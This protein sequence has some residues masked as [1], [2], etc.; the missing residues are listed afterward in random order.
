MFLVRRVFKVK[1]GTGRKAAE[2]ITQI[3]QMYDGAG[4]RTPSRV[5]LSGSTVPGP[6]D[7]VYMDW[8]AET[9][10]SAYRPDNVA[11]KPTGEDDL[12]AKLREYQE[13][14]YIEFY[15]MYSGA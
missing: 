10:E 14:T 3:G 6:A 9:L 2:V 1:K 4:Q 12:F 5:Y 11:A 7:T 15:E 13:E 8:T